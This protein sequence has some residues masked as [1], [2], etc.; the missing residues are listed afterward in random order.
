MSAHRRVQSASTIVSPS[1]S[2]PRDRRRPGPGSARRCCVTP[3]AATPPLCCALPMHPRASPATSRAPSAVAPPYSR[4]PASLTPLA[5]AHPSVLPPLPL[6]CATPHLYPLL[7][8]RSHTLPLLFVPPSCSR[9]P[10]SRS[11]LHVG[12]TGKC[13]MGEVDGGGEIRQPRSGG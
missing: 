7:H 5:L 12:P 1:C 10:R 9:R 13:K 8:V 6:L 3:V 4:A 11:I 2:R